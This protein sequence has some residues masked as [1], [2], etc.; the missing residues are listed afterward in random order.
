LD[1]LPEALAQVFVGGIGRDGY[2]D[3]GPAGGG[4]FAGDSEAG[5][6]SPAAERVLL[7]EPV[8]GRDVGGFG[9]DF[10]IAVGGC[11]L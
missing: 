7:R 6:D 2:D 1:L 5:D 9:F 10:E 4:F 8:L 11:G 3:R